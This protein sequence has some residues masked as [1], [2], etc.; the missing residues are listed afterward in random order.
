[1]SYVACTPNILQVDTA[2]QG[3]DV[4][5]DMLDQLADRVAPMDQA[6]SRSTASGASTALSVAVRFRR[7]LDFLSFRSRS[8]IRRC[9]S[10]IRRRVASAMAGPLSGPVPAIGSPTRCPKW[11]KAGASC[12]AN[13]SRTFR[14]P[15]PAV[16]YARIF[17]W[18]VGAL[19]NLIGTIL[20][21]T[22]LLLGGVLVVDKS[23]KIIYSYQE[24]TGTG[25]YS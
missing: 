5:V 15:A 25:S 8:E 17:G 14:G 24:K 12:C 21:T 6:A 22:G 9:P 16:R 1:M 4:I 13:H 23:G 18:I 11:A 2:D 10:A 20:L 19:A 3:G 7:W